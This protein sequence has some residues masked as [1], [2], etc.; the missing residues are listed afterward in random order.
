MR[1]DAADGVGVVRELHRRADLTLV[2]TS[3]PGCEGTAIL[4]TQDSGAV[5]FFS[6]A[7]SFPAAA[8]GADSISSRVQLVI[9]NGFTDARGEY[10]L[11]LLRRRPGLRAGFEAA[12]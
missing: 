3:A 6:T 8:L 4:A 2:C 1:A 7:T 9:P 5:L 11:E 12:A 10:A